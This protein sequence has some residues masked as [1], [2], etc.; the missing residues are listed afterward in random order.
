MWTQRDLLGGSCDHAGNFET[1]ENFTLQNQLLSGTFGCEA[2][3]CMGQGCTVGL[4][5]YVPACSPPLSVVSVVHCR[6][7]RI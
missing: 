6:Y 4:V 3:N 2:A 5:G 1:Y 7:Y